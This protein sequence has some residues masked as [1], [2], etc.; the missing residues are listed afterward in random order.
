MANKMTLNPAA[1][2]PITG[3][4]K[5]Y[6][7]KLRNNH[8]PR[9]LFRAWTSDSGGG[10]NANI[11]NSIAIVPHAFMPESGNNVSSSFYNTLESE[12]CRMASMHYGGGHSLS[13]FSSW[14]VSLALVLCYAKELSLKRERTHV[15]VMD[16]HEL[17]PDVLVWHVP[18]LINAG[19][20]ECLAF[21]R[22]RG[23]A[24]QAV[25][26]ETWVTTVC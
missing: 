23:R 24:Y 13:A 11:N 10:P 19:N 17:G 26:F 25:S 20:H 18:H 1:T 2:E 4:R 8:V 5:E 12:L 15:A 6:F 3:E 7:E 14:A 16:T 9:Y 22:I 21:G